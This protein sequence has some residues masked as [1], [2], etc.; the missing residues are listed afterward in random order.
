VGT[1][2]LIP[3]LASSGGHATI[4]QAAA[5]LPLPLLTL[6]IGGLFLGTLAI[7]RFSLR[8]GVPAILGV[9]LFGLFI[10]GNAELFS[11]GAIERLHTLSLSMLLFYAG[12]RTE[13]RSIRGFLEYGL[14]LA[15][16]GVVLSSLL[17]GLIVWFVSSPTA[18]GIELG[19]NQ[20]PLGVAMLI[21]SCLGST[22][23]GATLNVMRSLRQPL[24]PRLRSLL[25]FESSVNDPA[26]ILFLGV[27]IGFFSM[28]QAAGS[29]GV[30]VEQMQLFLQKIGSGL[31]VGVILGY[32]AR[33]CLE[34]LIE[35]DH[36]LLILG[37]SIAL[38]SYGC[39]EMLNGSGFI[40]AYVTGMFL[41]NHR[42]RNARITPAALL[43]TLLPFNTMTEITVFLIF[44]LSMH[45]GRILASLPEGIVVALGMM[46]VARPLSVLAFQRFSPF[47]L[48]ESLLVAWCGLRGAVPLALSFTMMEAI[49][50]L[51]GVNP[52]TVT[53]LVANAEVIVFSVVV[54]NLLIQGLSLPMVCRWL[55]VTPQEPAVLSG[56]PAGPAP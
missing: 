14:L 11:H 13:L 9:L 31:V 25:E 15:L 29:E 46:L 48:R 16:G 44:G 23:A 47:S 55:T 37:V 52:A 22:D 1:P 27:V 40:S 43:D 42:Y 34:K 56:G 51:R 7:S 41:S 21:A 39:S 54:V 4:R 19:F 17:L 24:P 30:L 32:G 35:E 2:W 10:N 53:S 50:H 8:V 3:L 20:M 49:P 38:L 26:A 12:L 36:E 33:F 28:N 45:P 5:A 18:G 6:T